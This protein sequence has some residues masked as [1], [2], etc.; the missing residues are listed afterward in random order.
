VERE[1]SSRERNAYEIIR[2]T[3]YWQLVDRLQLN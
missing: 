2:K 3:I 1:L